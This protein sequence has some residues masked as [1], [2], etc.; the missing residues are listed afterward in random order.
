MC[1][2]AHLAVEKALKAALVDAGAP[3]KRTHDLVELHLRCTQLGRPLPI[4]TVDLSELNP[5]AIDGRYG[6]ELRDG[7]RA[8]VSRFSSFARDVVADIKAELG[9]I[10]ATG[11]CD[12]DIA[13]WHSARHETIEAPRDRSIPARARSGCRPPGLQARTLI[14]SAEP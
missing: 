10:E 3:F 12:D 2:I 4:D 5:W 6:A 7:Q 11:S 8:A 9:L 13:T 1:F 14:P